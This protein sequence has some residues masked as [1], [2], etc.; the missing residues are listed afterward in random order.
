MAGLDPDDPAYFVK[1]AFRAIEE[2]RQRLAAEQAAALL[3]AENP[4]LPPLPDTLAGRLGAELR[5]QYGSRRPPA[6][7]KQIAHEL[8][9]RGIKFSNRTL[10]SAIKL[11]WS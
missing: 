10:N 3:R 9:E 8:R 1:K 5:V 11:A 6:A 2:N 4:P 7:I